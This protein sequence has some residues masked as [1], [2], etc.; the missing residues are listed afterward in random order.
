MDWWLCSLGGCFPVLISLDNSSWRWRSGR[1]QG[2]ASVNQRTPSHGRPVSDSADDTKK[3]MVSQKDGP[4]GRRSERPLYWINEPPL[5]G[6][7]SPK[8]KFFMECNKHLYSECISWS[9]QNWNVEFLYV[10]IRIDQFWLRGPNLGGELML[11]SEFQSCSYP[12]RALPL[13]FVVVILMLHRNWKIIHGWCW[14]L[15]V[16]G[17]HLHRQPI[18]LLSSQGIAGTACV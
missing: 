13:R 14:H 16:D 7:D 4:K 3:L 2:P 8:G 11:L 15:Y 6:W 12:H 18:L 9:E 1:D 10:A 17:V 5:T